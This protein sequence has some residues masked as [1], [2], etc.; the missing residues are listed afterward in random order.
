MPLTPPAGAGTASDPL[1]R[2]LSP[3]GRRLTLAGVAVALIGPVLVTAV[4]SIPSR[5]G[6]AVPARL[7]T[8]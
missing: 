5:Q 8:R 7:P 3:A 1:D 2:L 4:A 6:T